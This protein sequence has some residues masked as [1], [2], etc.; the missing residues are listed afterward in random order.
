MLLLWEK[1]EYETLKKKKQKTIYR[2]SRQWLL[3]VDNW[4]TTVRW[5]TDS[6]CSVGTGSSLSFEEMN[7]FGSRWRRWLHNMVNVLRATELYTFRWLIF[8][9]TIHVYEIIR[10]YTLNLYSA[11]CHI[12]LNKAG[13]E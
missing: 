3:E 9:L 6:D 10:L 4:Q 2:E 11:G 1:K 13:R 5:W 12:D 8:Y 7:M